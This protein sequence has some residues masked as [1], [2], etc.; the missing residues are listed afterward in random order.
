LIAVEAVMSADYN[1]MAAKRIYNRGSCGLCL[2][3][4]VCQYSKFCRQNFTFLMKNFRLGGQY[5]KPHQIAKKGS[6]V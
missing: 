5:Q 1:K 3:L 4:V 2:Q 6:T